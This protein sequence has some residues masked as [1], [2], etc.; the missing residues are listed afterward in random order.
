MD[1][2]NIPQGEN[3]GQFVLKIFELIS[4]LYISNSRFYFNKYDSLLF[5]ANIE[6]NHLKNIL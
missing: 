5:K 6:D 1:K 2:T 4:C 3:K